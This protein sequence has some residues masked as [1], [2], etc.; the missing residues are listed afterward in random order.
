VG[1]A[2]AIVDELQP[3]GCGHGGGGVKRLKK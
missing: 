1:G 2:V 3:A